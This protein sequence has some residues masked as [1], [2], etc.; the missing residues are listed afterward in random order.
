MILGLVLG[1]MTESNLRRAISL[2]SGNV[3]NV[4][5]KP[6]TATLLIACVLM[7]T[8]PVIMKFLKKKQVQA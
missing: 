2:E 6:I 5:S 7:L 1:G 8:L 4:L 3:M